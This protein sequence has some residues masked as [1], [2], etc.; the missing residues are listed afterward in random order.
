[1]LCRIEFKFIS[2]S[3][4]IRHHLDTCNKKVGLKASGTQMLTGIV[5]LTMEQIDHRSD[6]GRL[7][8]VLASPSMG[9]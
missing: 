7:F 1:M 2:H 5:Q 4:T 9:S 6:G 8:T 3:G